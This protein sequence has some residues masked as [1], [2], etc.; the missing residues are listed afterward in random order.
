MELGTERLCPHWILR[1]G[2]IQTLVIITSGQCWGVVNILQGV[3]CE[4][5]PHWSRWWWDPGSQVHC[6]L[7]WSH[8]TTTRRGERLEKWRKLETNGV[9]NNVITLQHYTAPVNSGRRL[10]DRE[11]PILQPMLLT[12]VLLH[13]SLVELCLFWGYS[14][15]CKISSDIISLELGIRTSLFAPLHVWI[16]QDI[17]VLSL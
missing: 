12:V 2:D 7:R 13:S 1:I 5:T 8:L 6:L 10:L 4:M 17:F 3:T 14:E 16:S 9:R 11:S 15:M